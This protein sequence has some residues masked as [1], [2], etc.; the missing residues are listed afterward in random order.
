MKIIIGKKTLIQTEGSTADDIQY[1]DV[2]TKEVYDFDGYLELI[3]K[4]KK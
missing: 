3:K 2:K 4:E 1:I